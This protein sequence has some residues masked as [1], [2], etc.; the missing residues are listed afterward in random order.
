MRPSERARALAASPAAKAALL[1]SPSS[2]CDRGC[3]ASIARPIQRLAHSET[4]FLL[5]SLSAATVL[6]T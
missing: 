1:L 4:S 3:A 2:A 6:T 5:A